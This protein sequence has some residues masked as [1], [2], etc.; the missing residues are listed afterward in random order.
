[1]KHVRVSDNAHSAIME[2]SRWWT[3]LRGITTASEIVD[4]ALIGMLQDILDR[5]TQEIPDAV[6][7]R[8][9]RLLKALEGQ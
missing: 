5:D 2:V 7:E 9:V 3:S 6:R 4:T 1:M 8:L